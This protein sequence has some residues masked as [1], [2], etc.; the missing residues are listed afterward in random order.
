MTHVK[1]LASNLWQELIY[2]GHLLSVGASGI[3]LSML[4]LLSLSISPALLLIP[5]LSA[6]IIYIF[7]HSYEIKLDKFSNPERVIYTHR[8]RNQLKI[9]I[10]IYIMALLVSLLFTNL[11]TFLFILFIVI[12]GVLYTSKLKQFL[13]KHIT[14]SKNYY[15]AF[16]WA[17]TIFLIPLELQLPI[18]PTYVYLFIFIFTRWI[19]NSVFF[20]IKDMKSDQIKKLKT[21]PITFGKNKTIFI[22]HVINILTIIPIYIG[23]H[24]NYLPRTIIFLLLTT[25]IYGFFYLQKSKKLNEKQLR[26]LSYIVVD[27]EYL[28]WPILAILGK[29]I[30]KL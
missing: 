22:L 5:Y 26:K 12:S 6:Q 11:L 16:F 13:T 1:I 27:A 9:L 21:L 2:G 15:T 20:D 18:T 28:F 30:N 25:Y 7:N 17:T 29:I 10:P 19:I 8:N 24:F 3:I 14:G 4:L 23:I